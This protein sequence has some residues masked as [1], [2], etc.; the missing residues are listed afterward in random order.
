[1]Q[2]FTKTNTNNPKINIADY[3]II[4]TGRSDPHLI[5]LADKLVS[6]V[7]HNTNYPYHTE[8]KQ[9]R[10]GWVLVDLGVVIVQL[11]ITEKRKLYNLEALYC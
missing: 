6:W 9:Q 1:M 3:V 10:S 2:F 8:G 4:A 5:A 11:F 7:K